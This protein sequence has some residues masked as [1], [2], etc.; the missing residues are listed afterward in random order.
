MGGAPQASV[1]AGGF[2]TSMLNAAYA[3]ATMAHAL[4]FDNTWY[5]LNHPTSPTLP[6]IL[7]IAE[8]YK[9]SGKRIIEAIVTAFEVQARVR[10]AATGL[11]TGAGFHK[12]GTTGTSLP[13]LYETVA[14][15]TTRMETAIA[16]ARKFEVPHAFD[17]VERMLVELPEIDVVCVSVRPAVHHQ[18]AMAALWAGKHVYCEHPLGVS[19]APAGTVRRASATNSRFTACGMPPKSPC[20]TR[21]GPPSTLIG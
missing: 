7:A 20:A 8:N 13:D 6:A 10:L 4:D 12:P 1:V 9:L 14:A 15:C 5:P 2:K 18:V 17:S 16:T 19:T 11:K 21:V 3:N